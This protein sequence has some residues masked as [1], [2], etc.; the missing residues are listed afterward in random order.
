M[1]YVINVTDEDN[2]SKNRMIPIDEMERTIFS[3][4]EIYMSNPQYE[5]ID[6]EIIEWLTKH[7]EG[8]RWR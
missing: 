4:I 7:F 1:S 8:I 3:S 2:M 6:W 5:S